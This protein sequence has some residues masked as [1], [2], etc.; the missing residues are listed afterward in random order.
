M[1]VGRLAP[2]AL[3]I[4]ATLILGQP[5]TAAEVTEYFVCRADEASYSSV[6]E[7]GWARHKAS[8]EDLG[9]DFT[10][11]IEYDPT[12]K[13]AIVDGRVDTFHVVSDYHALQMT[14][15]PEYEEEQ[16]PPSIIREQIVLYIGEPGVPFIWTFAQFSEYSTV[17]GRCE[18][19]VD[20]DGF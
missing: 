18:R 12:L 16:G 20:A 8:S 13:R 9:R 6:G 10:L 4:S 1:T 7:S 14:T 15:S 2:V 17:L 11:H 19:R 5:V 3:G